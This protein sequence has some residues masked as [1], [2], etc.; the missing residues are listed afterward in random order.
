MQTVRQDQVRR[1]ITVNDRGETA[2]YQE[3]TVF[4][5]TASRKS[6]KSVQERAKKVARTVKETAKSVERHA[7]HLLK[8]AGDDCSA[9]PAPDERFDESYLSAEYDPDDIVSYIKKRSDL[10]TFNLSSDTKVELFFIESVL[11]GAWAVSTL[12]W[13]MAWVNEHLFQNYHSGIELRYTKEDGTAERVVLTAW[14]NS[15]YPVGLASCVDT[16]GPHWQHGFVVLA[17]KGKNDGFWYGP[18]REGKHVATL[19][20]DKL[21]PLMDY[22]WEDFVSNT[23]RKYYSTAAVFSKYPEDNDIKHA[24]YDLTCHTFSEGVIWKAG[25]LGAKFF[26]VA[27]KRNYGA[28]VTDQ[29]PY[30]LEPVEKT[31][32]RLK[33]FYDEVRDGGEWFWVKKHLTTRFLPCFL[34]QDFFIYNE[35]SDEYFLVKCPVFRNTYEYMPMPPQA[36]Q[37]RGGK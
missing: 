12:D 24:N 2:P 32:E 9:I 17:T 23:N 20:G 10:P 18:K 7:Q 34:R 37:P 14:G 36:P 5:R 3:A 21:D 11:G 30:E 26:D 25:E 27:V 16:L 22:V 28:L 19:D 15:Q 4:R 31:D 33:P 13:I 6:E 35:T 1:D 29:S 8:T